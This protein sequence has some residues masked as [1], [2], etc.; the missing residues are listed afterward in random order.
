MRL[1]GK[2]DAAGGPKSW[3]TRYG[4][5]ITLAGLCALLAW[6]TPAFLT[7]QN[8]IILVR[9]ISING[10]LAVGVTFVLLTGGVDLSLGSM[11]ALTG[12]VAACFAHPGEYPLVVPLVIGVA[13]GTLCGT[14][15]GLVI[16][17]GR[18]APFIVTLGMMTVA[19]GLALVISGGKPVSNLS[20]SFVSGK[21]GT[22][23]EGATW[24][25][26][27]PRPRC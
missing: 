10:I 16:T 9:Q 20:S 19:R 22:C 7:L 14:V 24:G 2:E 26:V 27:G 13:T 12:V 5:M 11:V 23:S 25:A 3:L 6:I 21:R 15:N 18:V 4:L 1:R 17:L 8:W